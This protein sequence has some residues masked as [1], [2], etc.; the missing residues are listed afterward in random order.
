AAGSDL[1]CGV[2]TIELGGDRLPRCE[3]A[4]EYRLPSGANTAQ[5]THL[6]AEWVVESAQ[7][8][9]QQLTGLL[10]LGFRPAQRQHSLEQLGFS[11]TVLTNDDVDARREL[12]RQ[13]GEGSEVLELQVGNHAAPC[14]CAAL[15]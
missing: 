4:P 6:P 10:S 12:D 1:G 7:L 14:L 11:G 15:R 9:G 13:I 3:C 5:L 8:A 2:V